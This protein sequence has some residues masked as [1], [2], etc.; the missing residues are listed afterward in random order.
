MVGRASREGFLGAHRFYHVVNQNN[1]FRSVRNF[2]IDLTRMP[3]SA[4]ATGLHWQVSQ[5]TSLINVVVNMSTASGNNH[6][7]IVLSYLRTH[8]NLNDFSGMFMENGSGG[9]M[10]GMSAI[11]SCPEYYLNVLFL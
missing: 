7:G 2:V 5:A 4:T 1:F 8:L 6:Q 3:A 10:G 9:F 11:V